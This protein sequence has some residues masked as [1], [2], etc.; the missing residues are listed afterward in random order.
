[1]LTNLEI[2]IDYFTEE[3]L[4]EKIGRLR[5]SLISVQGLR[6]WRRQGKGPAA[7]KVGRTVCYRVE[8]VDK[9][10]RDW[11]SGNDAAS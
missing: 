4:A 2:A 10:L 7:A 11:R 3:E 1:M 8:S 6:L 9:G 5:G